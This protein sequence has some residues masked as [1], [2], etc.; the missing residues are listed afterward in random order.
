VSSTDAATGKPKR[1]L[2]MGISR[3]AGGKMVE[4]WKIGVP[5]PATSTPA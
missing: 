5:A 1:F 2:V 3:F 4:E